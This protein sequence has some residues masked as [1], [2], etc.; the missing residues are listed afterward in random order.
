MGKTDVT[1]RGKSWERKNS[2]WIIWSFFGLA[3]VGFTIIGSKTKE[4]KWIVCGIVYL[5]SLIGG[6]FFVDLFDGEI[7]E[8][9][10]DVYALLYIASIVHCFIAKKRYL[11]RYDKILYEKEQK[12]MDEQIRRIAM[13]KENLEKQNQIE[14]E[15]EKLEKQNQINLEKIRNSKINENIN[16]N[17]N[18]KTNENMT[19]NKN[20]KDNQAQEKQ[21]NGIMDWVEGIAALFAIVVVGWVAI[22]FVGDFFGIGETENGYI[23]EEA[24]KNDLTNNVFIVRPSER[25]VDVEAVSEKDGMVIVRVKV[26]DDELLQYSQYGEDV[27]EIYY[28]YEPAAD[29]NHYFSCWGE[30]EDDVKEKLDW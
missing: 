25:Q 20:K 10:A 1:V 28:G 3:G 27:D 26:K 30:S 8:I 4:K 18:K 14:L 13:E 9:L 16:E 29:S 23:A 6:L 7:G 15:K 19:E 24:C 11:I 5:I 17:E 22:T 12:L 2:L 21:S